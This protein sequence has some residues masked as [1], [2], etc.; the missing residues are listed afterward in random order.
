MKRALKYIFKTLSV[1]VLLI[2]MLISSLYLPP[3]QKWAVDRLSAWVEKET[4][5]ELTV[6][7]IHL[8]P[9]LDLRLENVHIEKAPTDVVDVESAIVDLD[10]SRLLMLH[11]GVEAIEFSK[12]NIHITELIESVA[13]DANINNITL[14]ADD[15]DLR[16]KCVSVPV[17]MLDSCVL[18]IKLRETPEDTS[19]SSPL[20]WQIDVEKVHVCRSKIALHLPNDTMCVSA[21]LREATLD[22]ADINLGNAAY[23]IGNISIIADSLSYDI[24]SADSVVGLDMSHLAFKN[25]ELSLDEFSYDQSSSVL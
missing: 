3:I 15:I 4:E 25:V 13:L 20:D 10:L 21:S 5:F 16:K 1:L 11:I 23:G 18:D 9:L 6:G 22:A 24:P 17:A 12:G 2:A 8:T 19:A 7:S 14:I